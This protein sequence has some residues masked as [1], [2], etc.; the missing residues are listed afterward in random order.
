M[1]CS[2]INVDCDV[3]LVA[4]KYKKN[5]FTSTLIEEEERVLKL[6]MLL[7][8]NEKSE[9]PKRNATGGDSVSILSNHFSNHLIYVC[10][11]FS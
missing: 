7:E 10:Y 9:T 8:F 3:Q 5:N 1:R 11:I 6:C 2:S 4:V